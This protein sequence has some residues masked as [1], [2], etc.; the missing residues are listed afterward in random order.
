MTIR[1][2][3]RLRQMALVEYLDLKYDFDWSHN[4][5]VSNDPRVIEHHKWLEQYETKPTDKPWRNV[6]VHCEFSGG[7]T[8][9]F[10]GMSL[11]ER[12]LG[13][14]RKRLLKIIKKGSDKKMNIVKI[15]KM[16]KGAMKNW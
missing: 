9:V 16:K 12:Q 8:I 5:E 3:M 13:I 11:A 10:P 6:P 7:E 15:Y 1:E 4:T 2:E 14:G